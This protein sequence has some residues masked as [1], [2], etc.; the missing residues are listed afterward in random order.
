[1]GNVYITKAAKFLPNKPIENDHIE[2]YLG[3]IGG[4]PSRAKNIILRQNQIKTRYYAVDGNGRF[5]HTN[6]QMTAEAIS[7][8]LDTEHR[9]S[10]VDA[11]YCGTSSPDQIMPSHAVMVHG[12]LKEFPSIEVANFSGVCCSGAHALQYAYISVFSGLKKNVICTGSELA[13]SVVHAKNFKEEY[14]TRQQVE[15]NPIIAFDKDF[16]RFMLSDGAGALFISNIP[17]GLSLKID[18]MESISYANIL[19]ACMYQGAIKKE[20]GDLIGWKM[21]EEQEWLKDSIFSVKQDIRLLGENIVIKAV[22]HI[23]NSGL[24]HNLDFNAINYF[25]PHISSM[26]FCDKLRDRM[27]EEGVEVAENKWFLNLSDVGNVGSASIYLMIE[28][29]FYSGKLQEGQKIYLFIPESGRFSYTTALLT[30]TK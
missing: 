30:V 1:M 3:M 19:P 26:Y 6:A 16:L 11:I 24:K 13:S 29:L 18:W 28:E 27:K 15:N 8:L 25:L 10:D 21:F 7:L 23:K 14:T 17:Q 22:E 20:N 4:K 12:E 2:K 9:A 5:T